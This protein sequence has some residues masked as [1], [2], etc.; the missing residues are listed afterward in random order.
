LG[1][2]HFGARLFATQFSLQGAIEAP[3]DPMTKR[4]E[5]AQALHAP[6]QHLF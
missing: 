3:I 2:P 1:S 4:R 5:C 6:K